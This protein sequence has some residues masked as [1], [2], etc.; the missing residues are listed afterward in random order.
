MFFFISGEQLEFND[1]LYVMGKVQ[2]WGDTPDEILDAFMTFD[3]NKTGKK[4]K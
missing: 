1:F 4:V 3:E 2:K